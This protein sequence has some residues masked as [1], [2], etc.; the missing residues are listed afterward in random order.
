MKTIISTN[1]DIEKIVRK[2][3]FFDK[4]PVH[5]KEISNDLKNIDESYFYNFEEDVLIPLVCKSHKI[6]KIIKRHSECNSED[7]FK[8]EIRKDFIRIVDAL[9]LN[10]PGLKELSLDF[11]DSKNISLYRPLTRKIELSTHYMGIA[12]KYRDLDDFAYP[13]YI[14]IH[15]IAH[16][17]CECWFGGSEG[18]HDHKFFY[19]FM[20]AL[21]QI[22]GQVVDHV[23]SKSECMSLFHENGYTNIR[24]YQKENGLFF[25]V[26]TN[27]FSVFNVESKQKA[28][29]ICKARYNLDM[30]SIYSEEF[31]DAFS[32]GYTC[33]KFVFAN[34]KGD[35]I[36]QIV[37]NKRPVIGY[38][39]IVYK[40]SHAEKYLAKIKIEWLEYINQLD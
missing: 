25:C 5:L 16:D 19:C 37:L 9:E 13:I 35:G 6:W 27:M 4:I 40:M 30:G 15:E 8:N 34:K 33:Y 24:E 1:D 23:Y 10:I 28:F 18:G 36:Y 31:N 26:P 11:I 2:K 32:K 7:E 39:C 12:I 20:Y 3:I 21:R 17:I 29:G 14:L 38:K 22:A